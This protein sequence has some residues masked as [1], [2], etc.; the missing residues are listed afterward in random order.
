MRTCEAP[1]PISHAPRSLPHR[2]VALFSR[3]TW[4]LAASSGALILYS[5]L[6]RNRYTLSSHNIKTTDRYSGWH[7]STVK[8]LLVASH[9]PELWK[10]FIMCQT[11]K[12][13]STPRTIT[14]A[15]GT[16]TKEKACRHTAKMAQDHDGKS[17][18]ET[19]PPNFKLFSFYY[20][21]HAPQHTRKV[22]ISN[23]RPR[24]HN[25]TTKGVWLWRRTYF[26]LVAFFHW[27]YS[28]FCLSQLSHTDRFLSF[29]A[30]IKISSDF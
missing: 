21:M 16:D 26:G 14:H 10:H 24:G 6:K 13:N 9:W 4:P 15:N 11:P 30:T 17:K 7:W 12:N 5:S 22:G 3:V 19:R 8:C 25:Q 23:I 29:T 2:N 28:F 27:F 18:L 1:L 20:L